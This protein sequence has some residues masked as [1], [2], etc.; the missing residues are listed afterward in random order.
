MV[1]D[2]SKCHF[3]NC[4]LVQTQIRTRNDIAICKTHPVSSDI[5]KKLRKSN[6]HNIREVH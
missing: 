2:I 3:E 4:N 6:Y 5:K 1:R